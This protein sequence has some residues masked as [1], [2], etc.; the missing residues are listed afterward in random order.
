MTDR[1]RE[2]LSSN[3]RRIQDRIAA[4]CARAGRDPGT[5][6]T[7]AV[8]KSA[9]LETVRAL[10]DLGVR[11]LAENRVQAIEERARALGPGPVWHLVGTLQT[12]KV[13]KALPWADWIHSVDRL[14]LAETLAAAGEASGRRPVLLIE[15]NAGG[16]ASKQGA[17]PDDAEELIAGIRNR[18][19][20][21]RVEGLMT[22]APLAD[23]PERS[24]PVF[25]RLRDLRDRLRDRTGLPLAE[26]SMG[27]TQ[28][29][30]VAVGEGATLL[31]IGRAF[32][33]GVPCRD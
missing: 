3:R 13:R 15:V 1:I 32:F 16:E 4:A 20:S 12:N 18:F 14:S 9:A 23:D 21:L 31:R 6:R 33:E 30:P 22:M 19:P 28:D 7:V 27:M 10:A 24:R 25:A 2:T 8:T 26:L 11:D 5:V 17:D 29:Y